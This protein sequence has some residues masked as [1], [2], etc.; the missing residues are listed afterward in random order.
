MFCLPN[1][2]LMQLKV[3]HMYDRTAAKV[4]FSSGYAS[5]FH[6]YNTQQLCLGLYPFSLKVALSNSNSSWRLSQS[7]K[8]FTLWRWQAKVCTSR[9]S[10]WKPTHSN[11]SSNWTQFSS[12]SSTSSHEYTRKSKWTWATAWQTVGLLCGDSMALQLAC[13]LERVNSN[14]EGKKAKRYNFPGCG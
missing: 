6:G 8:L 11:F 7:H 12:C 14:F 4:S 13:F 9:C 10:K 3:V 2:L 5:L 1:I